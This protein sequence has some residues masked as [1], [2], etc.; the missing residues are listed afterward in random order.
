MRP[1]GL[2]ERMAVLA[3][4]I[5]IDFDYFSQHSQHGAGSM[6]PFFLPI[7]MPSP[8][9][10]PPED[11]AGAG[12]D[13]AEGAAAGDSAGVPWQLMIAGMCCPIG[14]CV[15]ARRDKD[16]VFVCCMSSFT[17]GGEGAHVHVKPSTGGAVSAHSQE[18]KLPARTRLGY[19]LELCRA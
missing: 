16:V 7:P 5:S 13:G 17:T 6:L 19:F 12:A 11:A 4:A 3:A 1:L 15:S 9:Y 2:D 18:P 14:V 8:P 10:P